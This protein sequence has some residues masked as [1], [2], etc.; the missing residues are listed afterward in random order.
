MLGGGL[1]V[2]PA[3]G[4]QNKGKSSF[5]GSGLFV[6]VSQCGSDGGLAVRHGG[7]CA[8]WSLVAKGLLLLRVR[9]V[10]RTSNMKISRR[11]LADYVKTLHQKACRTCTTINFL[12]STNQ[13][14]DS[15]R[16][17]W[18]CRRQILNSLIVVEVNECFV[19]FLKKHFGH[20]LGDK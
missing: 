5:T 2:V 12:H 7:F 19:P 13:I 10:V 4:H 20:N 17:R 9:V 11:R 14:I 1:I 6:L 15:R 16:R 3:L 18:R 8:T